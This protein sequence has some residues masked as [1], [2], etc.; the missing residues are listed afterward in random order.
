MD[1]EKS[2]ENCRKLRNR[3]ARRAGGLRTHSSR[4][5]RRRLRAISAWNGLRG[6][7]KGAIARVGTKGRPVQTGRKFPEITNGCQSLNV[8]TD[9]SFENGAELREKGTYRI[10]CDVA[11]MSSE[12]LIPIKFLIKSL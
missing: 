2:K 10:F 6:L 12:N 3:R 5:P 9:V 4:K 8:S 1:R 11:Y 7:L